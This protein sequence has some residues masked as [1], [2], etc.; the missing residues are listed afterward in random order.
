MPGFLSSPHSGKREGNVHAQ[1]CADTPRHDELRAADVATQVT[2]DLNVALAPRIVSKP[3]RTIEHGPGA[4][5]VSLSSSGRLRDG[6][7]AA[8]RAVVARIECHVIS[9]PMRD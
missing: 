4:Q 5:L 1:P 3:F 6:P 8:V 2:I 7:M 9:L